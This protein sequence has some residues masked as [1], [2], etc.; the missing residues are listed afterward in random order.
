MENRPVPEKRSLGSDSG[1]NFENLD[2]RE[3]G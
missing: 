2:G 3:N 1:G